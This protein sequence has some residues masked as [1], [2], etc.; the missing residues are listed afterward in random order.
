MA[1]TGDEQ[2]GSGTKGTFFEPCADF[3]LFVKKEVLVVIALRILIGV[4]LLGL[5]AWLIIRYAPAVGN[6][7]GNLLIDLLSC[8]SKKER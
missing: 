6:F 8:H 4:F 3:P 7:I 5:T 2:K 1:G